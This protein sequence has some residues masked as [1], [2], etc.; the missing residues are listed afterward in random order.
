LVVA[1]EQ[2]PC[3]GAGEPPGLGD[4]PLEERRQLPLAHERDADGDELVEAVR[5]AV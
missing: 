4:D 5:R 3:L 2:R 1:Q